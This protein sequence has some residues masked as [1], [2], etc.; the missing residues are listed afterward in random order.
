MGYIMTVKEIKELIKKSY[1][2]SIIYKRNYKEVS[3]TDSDIVVGISA[4]G[5]YDGQVHYIV[6]LG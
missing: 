3:P 6:E 1:G 2:D 5:G 4:T